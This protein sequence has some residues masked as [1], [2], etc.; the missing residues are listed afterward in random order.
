MPD[1]VF[2]NIGK[3]LLATQ[4]LRHAPS[5]PLR[6]RR[7]DRGAARPDEDHNPATA[8]SLSAVLAASPDIPADKRLEVARFI[9]DLTASH[10]GGWYSVISPARRRLAGGDEAGDLAQLPGGGEGRTGR[11]PARARRAGRWPPRLQATRPLL[12]NGVCT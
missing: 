9:E 2:A 12:R 6:L 4:D 10:Q 8:A 3:L 1:P 11:A 5:R 7:P